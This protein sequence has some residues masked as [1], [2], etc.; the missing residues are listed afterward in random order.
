MAETWSNNNDHIKYY[1]VLSEVDTLNDWTGKTGFVHDAV[2]KVHAD[3]SGYDIYACGP[4]P[5]INAIV[6]S[7]PKKGLNKDRLYSDSFE[8]AAN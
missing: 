1:P 3:L 7:F 4:P 2:L 8:F 5:M 6:E